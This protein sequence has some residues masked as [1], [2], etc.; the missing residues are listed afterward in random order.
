[1]GQIIPFRCKP[2][3]AAGAPAETVDTDLAARIRRG[4]LSSADIEKR[5]AAAG[6]TD[7]LHRIGFV[8]W[9]TGV[10]RRKEETP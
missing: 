3:E 6:F 10:A 8:A 7:W 9:R 1:M 4:E 5:S 2:D